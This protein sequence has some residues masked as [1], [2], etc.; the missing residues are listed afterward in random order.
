MKNRYF[1]EWEFKQAISLI[2]TN[3]LVS[4]LKLAE[5]LQKYPK[6]CSAYTYYASVLITLGEFADAKKILDYF[7]YLQSENKINKIEDKRNAIIARIR[8]LTFE[9][10]YTEA[11]RLCQKY[12]HEL[13]DIGVEPLKYYY[14]QKFG[15][16]DPN[17]RNQH[18]YIFRQII[19]YEESDFLEHIKKHLSEYNED[20]Q[21]QS[22]CIFNPEFP[23]KDI[24]IE[25]KKNIPSDKRL[26]FNLYANTYIF[27]Y[28]DCGKVK[29]GTSFKSVDYFKVICFQNT[30]NIITMYPDTNCQRLP[31][32]IDL[33]YIKQ[34]LPSIVGN[35]L[36]KKPTSQIDKF[37]KRFGNHKL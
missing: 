5:Y 9:Q 25:I 35:R 23:L 6:D 11:S 7:D 13:N 15:E 1:N 24:L 26:F 27:K 2:E 36:I 31:H 18:T 17:K 12:S 32:I 3:P 19:N 10:K 28:D 4:K 21:K 33:N 34:S 37:N 22:A 14:R 8:L 20:S 30:D 16:L 29:E